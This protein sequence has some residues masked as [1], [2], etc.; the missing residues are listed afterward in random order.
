[1]QNGAARNTLLLVAATLLRPS[2][3]VTTVAMAVPSTSVLL[4]LT[5]LYVF[6]TTVRVV[7]QV[8]EEALHLVDTATDAAEEAMVWTFWLYKCAGVLLSLIAAIASYKWAKRFAP[9]SKIGG[10]EETAANA[11]ITAAPQ[12]TG[13]RLHRMFAQ[14]G[15]WLTESAI[16]KAARNQEGAY[17]IAQDASNVTLM[18][19]SHLRGGSAGVRVLHFQVLREQGDREYSVWISKDP[20]DWKAAEQTGTIA[21][22]V[23]GCSCVDAFLL[24]E[25]RRCRMVYNGPIC[26]HAAACLLV[27]ARRDEPTSQDR[28]AAAVAAGSVL[29]QKTVDGNSSGLLNLRIKPP[30]TNF[31]MIEKFRHLMTRGRAQPKVAEAGKPGMML[32]IKGVVEWK[33]KPREVRAS[34]GVPQLPLVLPV[35]ASPFTAG[36][37]ITPS[38]GRIMNFLN[39]AEAQDAVISE[40]QRPSPEAVIRLMAYTVD[41]PPLVAALCTA[42]AGRVEAAEED[43]RCSEFWRVWLLLADWIAANRQAV[44]QSARQMEQRRHLRLLMIGFEE[45]L[46]VGMPAMV[47]DSE[48]ETSAWEEEV[49]TPPTRRVGVASRSPSP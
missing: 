42:K 16:R 20:R 36:E 14:H 12:R 5:K 47:A 6:S 24:V 21:R 23:K 41:Y 44:M 29:L 31:W 26:K 19:E 33:P 49:V 32:A 18:P 38:G 27:E 40:I 37:G 7:N 35:A 43:H 9:S 48:T 2:E 30:L 17:R 11:E 8:P 39:G 46:Y 28:R 1:M 22:I 45:W 34:V 4:L 10:T 13:D 15:N 25:A 3:A